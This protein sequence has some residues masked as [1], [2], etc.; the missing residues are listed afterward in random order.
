MDLPGP[1]AHRLT[2]GLLAFLAL[3]Y[4]P[5]TGHYGLWDPWESHYAEV[6]R[7]MVERG[8]WISLWWPGSPQDPPTFWSKPVLTFW[9]LALSLRAFGLGR[10]GIEH[11]A[12]MTTGWR[13][14]WALRLPMVLLS[15][16]G[17]L[18]LFHL[19]RRTADRGAAVLSALL[20]ATASQWALLSRQVMT[21]MPFVM[22]M[23]AALC[24]AGLALLLP[25]AEVER[26]LPRRRWGPLRW[27][28]HPAFYGLLALYLVCV[29]PQLVV[30]AVQLGPFS[31]RLGG[32]TYRALGIVGVLP[33]A[34][35]C[36]ATVVGLLR[37]RDLRSIYLLFASLL[38]G[39]ATLAKG[40]AGL[41]MPLCAVVLFLVAAG[42]SRELRR[43]EILRGALVFLCVAG[44]WYAVMFLRHGPPF[45][46]EM[47]GEHYLRRLQGRHGDRGTFEYYLRQIGAGLF[48]W[49]GLVAASLV[50]C[51]RWLRTPRGGLVLFALC[52]FVAD[53]FIVSLVNTK[54]H[55]YILPALPPL[56][57]L[58]GLL[59]GEVC[60]A[61]PR[62]R[63]GLLGLVLL[64]LPLLW[65]SGR[66]LAAFPARI[67]W[68]FNYDY[69]NAP[70]TGRPWP[71]ASVYGLRY[72]Y[73]AEVLGFAMAATALLGLLAALGLR[74]PHPAAPPAPSS[75]GQPWLRALLFCVLLAAAVGVAPSPESVSRFSS[76][77][78]GPAAARPLGLRFA[79]LVPSAAAGLWLVFLLRDALPAP[80]ERG[81]RALATALGLLAVLWT[82][83]VLDR[84]LIDLSPHWSQKHLI[85]TY[86]RLRR[87]P[88]EPLVA[89]YMYWRGENFYTR[90]E[91]YDHRRPPADRSVIL[92][93]PGGVQ[94]R[95][96]LEG[97]RGRRIFFV[98]ERHRLELLRALLPSP[99]G[100]TLRVVDDSNNK[101]YLAVA[102]L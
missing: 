17:L 102:D 47:I 84:Y 55:H 4:V 39:L 98:L 45:W 44:P 25:E 61:Q 56:S 57:L 38:A 71:L 53:F 16:L 14:E 77:A 21:D 23:T 79:F 12:E 29:L 51:R 2:L 40:P 62:P 74:P 97:H 91:I 13:A 94:L 50:C 69:V 33:W 11:A 8:D 3:L 6:A 9:L 66:D 86:Y 36:F 1:S 90:N 34:V 82:G 85:A 52:W 75:G 64:G 27:P 15:L 19:V 83:W 41:A 92:N 73:G 72:E 93:D 43:L 20:L 67:G 7:Q 31:F 60:Q 76:S 59:L 54:F 35:L 63:D 96:Y 81:L 80:S 100:A 58:G 5:F 88:Q 10:P 65:L 49:S 28:H 18:A 87:G 101:V 89:W 95:A 42:R 70:G 37:V 32:R 48:P 30:Y 46:M 22:P 68:L 78:L 99:S 26:E 24:A